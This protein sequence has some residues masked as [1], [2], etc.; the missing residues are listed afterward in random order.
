M[1]VAR[2]SDGVAGGVHERQVVPGVG[3][4]QVAARG[5]EHA[6]EA[7]HEHVGRDLGAEVVVH[8]LQHRAGRE[9]PLRRC[10]KHAPG[11]RHHHRGGDAL[12][13]H[14]AHDQADQPV[15]EVDEVVEVA[16]HGARRAVVGRH[17]PAGQIGKHPRQEVLLDEL[18]DVELLLDALTLADLGLLLAHEL[19]HLHRR[20]GLRGEALEQPP[21]VRRVLL[22]REAGAQVQHPDQLALGHE[23]HDHGDA[24]RAHLLERRRLQLEVLQLD[25]AGCALQVSQDGIVGGDVQLGGGHC[26]LGRGLV[27]RDHLGAGGDGGLSQDDPA[28]SVGEHCHASFVPAGRSGIVTER[29]QIDTVRGCTVSWT[30]ET[31][32]CESA[33]SSICSRRRLLKP[34]TATSAS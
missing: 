27:G 30:V 9:H 6:V 24:L 25:G 23:R 28:N 17:L 8:A 2:S 3:V 31:S 12:V 20:R 34:C 13:G 4:A 5:I 14:V 11:S 22:I 21:V 33:S 26:G 18:G 19:A 10:A 32:S 7:G 1:P 16:A 15:G 29:S